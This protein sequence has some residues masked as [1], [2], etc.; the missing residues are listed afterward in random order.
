MRKITKIVL[1]TLF[2]VLFFIG[3]EI[4]RSPKDDNV[5]IYFL[6]VGQGDAALIERGDY[7]ILIDGGPDDKVL[8]E[9]GKVMPLS[10]RKIE[11]VILTH[12]HADHLVGINQVIDRYEVGKIYSSGSISTSNVYLEFLEKVKAKQIPLSIPG[13][14][15]KFSPYEN[16]ELEFIWPGKKFVGEAS[17]N[18]N[19]TS[20]ITRFCYF[21]QCAILTGDI[22]KDEQ[23]TMFEYYKQN[24]L[25]QDFSAVIYKVPHHGSI[26]GVNDQMYEE[27]KP[28]FSVISAGADNKFGHPHAA[29][30]TLAEKFKSKILRTD[31]DGTIEFSLGK[32]GVALIK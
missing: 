25:V 9:L 15:E 31:R 5:H 26:N 23:D 32:D 6:D 24:V 22:E 27:I 28:K 7:Q 11:A 16:A 14:Q 12:P 10:D 8:S 18:L 13:V 3:A 1:S 29:S 17:E 2:L 30:L 19:N 4:V 21:S 20:V